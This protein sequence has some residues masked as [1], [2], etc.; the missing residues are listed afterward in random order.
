MLAGPKILQAMLS[1]H[2]IGP[3]LEIKVEETNRLAHMKH[4][5]SPYRSTEIPQCNLVPVYYDI[6]TAGS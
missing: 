3:K 5:F 4:V 6:P 2:V 1:H